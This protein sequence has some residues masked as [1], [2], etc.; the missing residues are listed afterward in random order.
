[1]SNVYFF[2]DDFYF[3]K[4]MQ[5][6]CQEQAIEYTFITTKEKMH[7]LE[8]KINAS[9]YSDVFVFSF[10]NKEF[11]TQILKL[12]R[13]RMFKFLI[14]INTPMSAPSINIGNW[15]VISKF[16][17]FVEIDRAVVMQVVHQPSTRTFSFTDREEHVWSLLRC[18]KSIPEIARYLNLSPKTI[19]AE[20]G[21]S[22]R[23]LSFERGNELIYLKYGH[24]FHG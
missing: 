11:L 17:S 1:M 18:G 4:G 22:L 24:I 13:R 16:N 19:Y 10:D 23:K 7:I 15:S 14:I 3:L 12:D 2:S 9:R 6:S 21:R 8:E 5:E 20:R